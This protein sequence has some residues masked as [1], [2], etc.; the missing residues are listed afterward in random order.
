MVEAE[1][2]YLEFDDEVKTEVKI[3]DNQVKGG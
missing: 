1:Q 2:D 3:G